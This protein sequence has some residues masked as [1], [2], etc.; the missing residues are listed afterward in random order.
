MEIKNYIHRSELPE[1]LE[2]KSYGFNS[3][4]EDKLVVE[5]TDLSILNGDRT[6]STIVFIKRIPNTKNWEI[7]GLGEETKIKNF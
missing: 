2:A 7:T 1:T 4:D 5:K 3:W 6:W